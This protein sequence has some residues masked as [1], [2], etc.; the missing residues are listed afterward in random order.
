MSTRTLVFLFSLIFSER[1]LSQADSILDLLR[2]PELRRSMPEDQR[3][4]VIYDYYYTLK[5]DRPHR[6][7]VM[8]KLQEEMEARKDQDLAQM[9][10]YLQ[11]N[12][13]LVVINT[14]DHDIIEAFWRR[15]VQYAHSKNWP[16][17]EAE[18][19]FNLGLLRFNLKHFG[20]GMEMMMQSYAYVTEHGWS[21]PVAKYEELTSLGHAFYYFGD[22]TTSL[23]YLKESRLVNIP[24]SQRAYPYQSLNSIGLCYRHLDQPDSAIYYFNESY[25]LAKRAQDTFWMGL[26]HGNIGS[27]YYKEDDYEKALPYLEEDYRTGIA[28]GV[29][30]SSVLASL[31]LAHIELKRGNTPA[32]EE[33]IRFASDHIERSILDNM[34][35]YY[36]N[37]YDYHKLKGD[38]RQALAFVDSMIISQREKNEL[39]DRHILDQA[40]MRVAVA[41][42]D[43]SLRLLEAARGRQILMR[44]AL[45][46]ILVLTALIALLWIKRIQFKRQTT[47]QQLAESEEELK[48]FTKSL[49][50]KNEQLRIFQE[51]ADANLPATDRSADIAELSH[52]S[53]LTEDDWKH[54]RKLFDAVYPGFLVRLKEKINDLSPAET[55]LLALTKL[56][57]QSS[58]MAS[59]LGISANSIRTSRYRLRKRLNLPEEGSLGELVDLI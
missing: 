6:L 8:K 30:G 28:K 26:T 1:L 22:W 58:D 3:K 15:K 56:Q 33:Y 38:T 25:E 41:K 29:F 57:I 31:S 10:Q 47:M 5:D 32:A 50:E 43:S 20:E 36:E 19:N 37:L 53:I 46:I 7:A 42:Y 55:R 23:R 17:L 27:T 16:T 14:A 4:L 9:L 24:L 51:K 21:S 2:S 54:F 18:A 39:L 48:R 44:N 34:V 52:Y 35:I 45:F 59:M 40:E 11:W 13:S 12:D 49:L